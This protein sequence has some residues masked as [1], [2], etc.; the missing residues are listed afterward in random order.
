MNA[1]ATSLHPTAAPLGISTVAGA[2]QVIAAAPTQTGIPVAA[3]QG[4][5]TYNASALAGYAAVAPTALNQAPAIA[6][7]APTYLT[8]QL[9]QQTAERF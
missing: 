6:G 4:L 1:Y 5:G 7:A 8:A 9:Q 3:T 2:P